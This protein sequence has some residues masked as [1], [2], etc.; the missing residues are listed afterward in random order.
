M[1]A[2]RETQIFLLLT[3]LFPSSNLLY[4]AL[5]FHLSILLPIIYAPSSYI[6]SVKIPRVETFTVSLLHK[7]QG[8]YITLVFTCHLQNE[9]LCYPIQ[10]CYYFFLKRIR[11]HYGWGV[12]YSS[13]VAS[14]DQAYFCRLDGKSR[15]ARQVIFYLNILSLLTWEKCI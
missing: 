7:T 12:T 2:M 3:K 5:S 13:N 15:F 10:C 14:C 11:G 4:D 8:S 6:I 1:R 9:L